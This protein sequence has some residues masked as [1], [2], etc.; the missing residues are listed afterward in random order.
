MPQFLALAFVGASLFAGYRWFRK[1]SRR[2]ADELRRV[3]EELVRQQSGEET[4]LLDGPSLVED[5]ETGIYRP[6]E[7]GDG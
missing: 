6:A 3:E 5:P 2:V 7:P 4:D 1:E